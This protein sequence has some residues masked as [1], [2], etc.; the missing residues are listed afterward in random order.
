MPI[1]QC[2]ALRH[3]PSKCGRSQPS[4]CLR[5]QRMSARYSWISDLFVPLMMGAAGEGRAQARQGPT[6]AEI[7]ARR[8]KVVQSYFD[9]DGAKVAADTR[10]VCFLGKEP[11]EVANARADGLYFA[12]DPTGTC[13][14]VLAR[15]GRDLQLSEFYSRYLT[16]V[17]G[18]PAQADNF[19][20]AITAAVTRGNGGALSAHHSASHLGAS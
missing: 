7:A 19:A 4:R 18:A 12:P 5:L 9:P 20:G 1:G 13:V 3:S 16:E 2:P 6:P 14:A 11:A 8:Q 17:H 10:R 15:A